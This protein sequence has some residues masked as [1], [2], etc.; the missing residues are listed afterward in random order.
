[1]AR[2]A[3]NARR[4]SFKIEIRALDNFQFFS[5]VLVY[6]KNVSKYIKLNI[7]YIYKS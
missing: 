4:R 1:M 5:V 2:A 7:Y 6:K 3:L